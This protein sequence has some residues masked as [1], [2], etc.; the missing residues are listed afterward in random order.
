MCIHIHIYLYIYIYTHTH[1]YI[2]VLQERLLLCYVMFK[3]GTTGLEFG[4]RQGCTVVHVRI[5]SA[6]VCLS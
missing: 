6:Q 1:M 3:Y 4:H 2:F 5:E